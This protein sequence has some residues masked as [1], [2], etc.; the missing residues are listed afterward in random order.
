MI[1]PN[2]KEPPPKKNHDEKGYICIGVHVCTLRSPKLEA[3]I[4]V[5]RNCKVEKKETKNFPDSTL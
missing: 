5:Q 2:K 3:M 1:K 4:Y